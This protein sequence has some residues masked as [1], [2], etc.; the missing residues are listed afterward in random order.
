MTRPL[1]PIGFGYFAALLIASF[2]GLPAASFL[3]VLSGAAALAIFLSKLR[4]KYPLALLLAVVFAAGFLVYSLSARLTVLPPQRYAGSAYH[5]EMEILSEDG[6]SAGSF[7]YTAKVKHLAETGQ[8]VDFSV[9]LSHGESLSVQIGDTVEALVRFYPFEERFGLSSKT[10][11]LAQGRV[12]GAYITDYGSIEVR[13][14]AR[15]P[16]SY[17]LAS[18]RAAVREKILDHYPLREG[19]VL[20]AMLVGLR[21]DI[22]AELTESYRKA[23]GSHILVIS[24]MHMA[25]FAQFALG[26]LGLLG[27]NRRKA[28]AV[29]LAFV[30]SFMFVSGMS[31]SVIRSGI[32]QILILIGIVIGRTP[33]P[34]NSLAAALL[35]M[36]LQNPFCVGDISL[37]LS[38]SA[39][40]GVVT[41]SPKLLERFAAKGKTPKRKR[42]LSLLFSPVC[43]SVGAILGAAPVQLYVFGTFSFS[44]LLTSL[45]T[46]YLSAWLIRFGV[47]AVLLL[48][49]PFL[50]PAAAPFVLL[51]GALAKAQNAV[52]LTAAALLPAPAALGGAYLPAAILIVLL[53]FLAV[54]VLQKRVTVSAVVLSGILLFTGS[55]INAQINQSGTRVLVID[56]PYASC[57][58]LLHGKTACI[59]QCGGDGSLI[60]DA[61]Q[62]NGIERIDFLPVSRK[63]E[64]IRCAQSLAAAFPAD[65]IL[66]PE[67]VFFPAENS[68]VRS[69]GYGSR[70]MTDRQV[71]YEVSENGEA[72]TLEAYGRRVLFAS[73]QILPAPARTP[74]LLI[75]KD[76]LASPAASYTLTVG[77]DSPESLP[78]TRDGTYFFTDGAERTLLRFQPD[79][80]VRAFIE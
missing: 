35:L 80:S 23:G 38:F 8:D 55:F 29:S 59:L 36:S 57:A 61:L 24:G 32:M 58:A 27:L 62:E 47:I 69:Y 2:A 12:L 70:G 73:G 51:S 44:G 43:T 67:T 65:F 40:L 13:P 25:I 76:V 11:Q 64:D 10:S 14:A 31:A 28:A 30:I 7:R 79:G 63:E 45:L 9:R 53:F 19:S 6:Q 60:T 4:R 75:T 5:A 78:L 1:I 52:V 50:A 37:L 39:T 68:T 46:L 26:A 34:L 33:D 66:V 77:T 56:A 71:L 15:R 17:Y 74:D 49:I 72:V 16:F 48:F 22:P 54:C 20:T 18:L 42:V 3:A 21:D 41:L